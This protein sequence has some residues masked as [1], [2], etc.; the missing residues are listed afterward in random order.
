MPELNVIQTPAT[1]NR[2]GAWARVRSFLP[3]LY[4]LAVVVAIVWLIRKQQVQLRF[5]TD[6]PIRVQEVHAFFP[7]ATRLEPDASERAGLWVLDAKG[8]TIGYVLRTS[9][10]SDKIVGYCGPTDTLV[11]LTPDKSNPTVVGIKVRSSLDTKQHVEDVIADESFMGTWDGKSWDQVAGMDPRAAG[12]E[13]VSGASLTSRA[14]ANG[15]R[16]RFA[17]SNEAAQAA[18]EASHQPMHV[19]GHDIGLFIVLA[20]AFAFTFTHLRSR[21]WLR[22]AFQLVLIGY[23]GFFNGQILA[24]SLFA[25]WSASAVPWRAAPGLALLA[26]AALIVPWFTRRQIYCSHICPHGAAQE[27]AGRVG[28]RWM[29]RPIALPRGVDRGLRWLPPMLIGLVL[30]VAMEKV[31]LNLAGIE[32]FDAYLVRAAGAATIAVAVI[33]L[34]AATFVPMAYCK[35]GCPTGT[36]LSFVRSHGRADAFARRDLVAGLLVM[37]AL[38]LYLW[39][40]P[41]HHAMVG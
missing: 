20:L 15:I 26:A 39:H 41:I 17:A 10:M 8:N 11:A 34:V 24:Q 30:F 36:L 4:R 5:D 28:R 31:P 25:G 32:P 7:A 23:V 22:R 21:V 16:H 27:W 37:L 3:R 29:K 19:S 18:A 35:Y 12:I 2:P 13:G 33:G 14:I 40:A 6:R 9:P 38:A 1:R